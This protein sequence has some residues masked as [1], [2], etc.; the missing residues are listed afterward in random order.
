M[1]PAELQKLFATALEVA[2]EYAMPGASVY[3]TVP[4]VFLKYFIQGLEDCG[5]SYRHCLAS[6][7]PTSESNVSSDPEAELRQAS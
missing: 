4:S 6:V 1:K 5:F 3:A 7:R 2:R